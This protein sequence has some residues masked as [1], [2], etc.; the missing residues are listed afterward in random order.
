MIQKQTLKGLAFALLIGLFTQCTPAPEADSEI[1]QKVN[2]YADTKL[3][4]NLIDKLSEQ[5]KKM[6]PLLIKAAKEMDKIFWL[7]SF[8]PKILLTRDIKDKDSLKL[9]M[10]NYGPWDRMREMKPFIDRYGLKPVGA[11]F[12]PAKLSFEDFIG[13]S[14]ES[15]FSS[16]TIIRKNKL[17]VLVSVPYYIAYRDELDKAS[18]LLKKAADLTIDETLKNYLNLRANALISNDFTKSELAWLNLKSNID[19]IIGAIETDEDKFLNTK[20]AYSSLVLLK[21]IEW[22]KKL[23]EYNRV[24]PD[25]QKALPIDE[26]YHSKL[27]STTSSLDVFD[28]IYCSGKYNAGPKMISL[29]LPPFVIAGTPI[30]SRKLQFKN[31]MQAKYDKILK[32]IGDIVIT[33]EQRQHV[34]FD[35]FFENTLFYEI[36]NQ[37]GFEHTLTDEVSVVQALKELYFTIEEEKS[38]VLS[39]F[40]L[41]K[42][43]EMNGETGVDIKDNYITYM[44]DIFRSIRF[45]SASPQSKANLVRFNYFKKEGAFT[46]NDNGT[47]TVDLD[48][49][50]AT[51]TNLVKDI[52]VIE[53]DGDYNAAKKLIDDNSD[54]TP[55]LQNDL[56]QITIAKIPKD[57]YFIQ[58][59]KELGL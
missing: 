22:S 52:L 31:V 51:I 12:Y 48:K 38:D 4:S 16:Y 14:D 49:M 44:A 2:E 53:G 32:P 3:T 39:L 24:L 27:T 23:T 50:K 37:L 33:E 6:L 28:V 19:I 57:I 25:L 41:T 21:D 17:G 30:T 36:G 56:D 9:A 47:Y 29:N 10:I 58:G 5:D 15:K 35:A 40:L 45:G 7:Q 11:R 8:G 1:M 42:L 13:I 55:S 46:K 18:S 54:I 34:T 20:A 43:K 26:E 59:K